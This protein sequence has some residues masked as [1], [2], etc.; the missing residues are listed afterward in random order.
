MIGQRLDR[1]RWRDSG[2]ERA[3]DSVRAATCLT[4]FNFVL[5]GSMKVANTYGPWARR[6]ADR[7]SIDAVRVNFGSCV[8]LCLQAYRLLNACQAQPS[9]WE[10]FGP[11]QAG[12]TGWQ[13]HGIDDLGL[14]P[15]KRNSCLRVF[16]L[17]PVTRIPLIAVLC[18]DK[19]LLLELYALLVLS[20][21]GQLLEGQRS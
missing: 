17:S 5:M 8:M 14:I 4:D 16:S 15:T 13:C 7:P 3:V 12:L 20:R 18:Q 2:T 21:L 11:S 19:K 1:R 9:R 6:V 10:L